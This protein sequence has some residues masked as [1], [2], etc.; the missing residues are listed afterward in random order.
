MQ[1]ENLLLEIT[2]GIATVTVNRP[3]AL[4]ALTIYTLAELDRVV[5]EVVG[6]PDVRAVVLTGAGTKAFVA[7]ADIAEMRDMSP[8]QARDLAFLAHHTYAAVERSPK[9]FIAAVN[10]YALGGGCELAMACDIRLAAETAKFGQPE[11]NLGIIPGFGGTQRLPRLVGKGRALE[12]ILTGEMVDAREALRIGLVNRVVAP[13]EL[14][15]EARQLARKIAAK[16]LVA[17]RLCKEAVGNGLEMDV[18][19]GCAY[20]AELFAHSFSTAD[21]KEGMGA[22]LGKRPAVFRDS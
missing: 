17:L 6:N 3:T 18:T 4:N 11:V 8:A 20:E 15:D 5:G 10:G 7:G 2:E 22:F 9:P 19:K 16:G 14:M 13:G 1:L 21:Q 12:M